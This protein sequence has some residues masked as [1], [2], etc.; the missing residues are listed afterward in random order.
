MKFGKELQLL[1]VPEWKTKYIQYE[2]LKNLID[3]VAAKLDGEDGHAKRRV[4]DP[5]CPFIIALEDNVEIMSTFYVS[6]RDQLLAT[7]ATL[8]DELEGV[9]KAEN[10]W[11][12]GWF[13]ECLS[14]KLPSSLQM[15]MEE[16]YLATDKL[17]SFKNINVTA[18][19]KVLKKYDKNTKRAASEAY[20]Q[21]LSNLQNIQECSTLT[22]MEMDLVEKFALHFTNDSRPLAMQRLR[23][24]E[25]RFTRV[26]WW[27]LASGA[28]LGVALMGMAVLIVG[29]AYSDDVNV[30]RT[31]RAALFR[32]FSG[33]FVLAIYPLCLCVNFYTFAKCSVN[34]R[35]MM[36]YSQRDKR[37]LRIWQV[38][39][40]AGSF[41]V[42]VWAVVPCVF[43]F[44]PFTDGHDAAWAPVIAIFAMFL[45]AVRPVNAIVKQR[46]PEVLRRLGRI[47]L[48]PYFN[49]TFPDF[50][51]ADQLT[52]LVRPILAVEFAVY[53][54]VYAYNADTE[55]DL[56]LSIGHTVG[57]GVLSSLPFIWRALQ[58]IRR[59]RDQGHAQ[60]HPH[61]TNMCKY[62]TTLLV[63]WLSILAS[64]FKGETGSELDNDEANTF[65]TLW[66]LA[67]VGST[68]FSLTWD[69]RM[70][71]GIMRN[72]E[73]LRQAK[74]YPEGYYYAAIVWNIIGRTA[75]VLSVSVGFF[76]SFRYNLLDL[77]LGLIEVFRRTSWNFFRFEVEHLYN[78]G[79]LRATQF[80]VVLDSR[81]EVVRSSQRVIP[82]P[83]SQGFFT[84]RYEPSSDREEGITYTSTGLQR[85]H[86]TTV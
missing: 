78:C 9:K 80:D 29:V 26:P 56:H 53:Y 18:I 17:R 38:Q 33:L 65:F 19:R 64:H 83:R 30:S 66:L 48:A 46:V 74:V 13:T 55:S 62:C 28:L 20:L 72:G 40:A 60:F 70:D 36:G 81:G 1:A 21:K 43:V 76:N 67:A 37:D 77:C 32:I 25:Q 73:L 12:H 84:E 75:W 69:F 16:I 7:W 6:I 5:H 63:I 2:D 39:L 59:Y 86:V 35:L 49:V 24:P 68:V 8:K 4:V 31:R 15:H 61:L 51:A 82:T 44:A 71:W 41:I 50:W 23:V 42:A 10:D 11:T 34:F 3:D 54:L 45:V 58:C 57:R 47:M 14:I 22:E 85:G 79:K 52:S 27:L